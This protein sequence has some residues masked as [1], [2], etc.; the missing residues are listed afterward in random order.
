[1]LGA[2][3]TIMGTEQTGTVLGPRESPLDDFPGPSVEHAQL[4]GEPGDRAV[5]RR[6]PDQ[7]LWTHR[8]F[9]TRPP[10]AP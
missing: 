9:K 6:L 8:R 1:M 10:G 4:S 2:R 7:Y 3:V 5:V